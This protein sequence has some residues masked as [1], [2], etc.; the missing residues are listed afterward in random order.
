MQI[1][2]QSASSRG[3]FSWPGN[4]HFRKCT[5]TKTWR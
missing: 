2:K 3:E 5:V 1:F 4:L